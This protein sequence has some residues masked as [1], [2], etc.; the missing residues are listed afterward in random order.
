[1]KI[2]LLLASISLYAGAADKLPQLNMQ[3]DSITVSGLSSGGYMASQFHIAHSDWVKGAGIIAAGPYYCGR[4]SIVTALSQCVN[5]LDK[6]IPLAEIT[7][8]AELWVKQ[9]RLAALDNLKQSKVWLL[10]GTLDQKVLSPINDALAEQY[11]AWSGSDNVQYIN[12]KPFAHHFPTLS[13]GHKCDIS[14]SPYLGN[15]AYDAAGELLSFLIGPLSPKAET[16]TGSLLTFDQKKLG[17]NAAASLA[18]QG[19]VYM[20]LSCQQGESCKLHISFH[21]CNQNSEAVANTFAKDN[22]LNE[23]ADSNHLVV[24]Y[25]QTKNSSLMPLNPQGCWDWWGYTDEDYANQRGQQI[26]AVSAMARYLGQK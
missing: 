20:P 8:Q 21:G 15:C 1:M 23:W 13:K 17:G 4:N 3:L 25:P 7:Q 5:K 24:L 26:Q 6:P 14:E 9:G 16:T 22:G 10:H 11:Q 19:Y 18:G 2:L 12:G